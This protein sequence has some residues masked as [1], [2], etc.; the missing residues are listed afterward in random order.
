MLPNGY[1]EG[2]FTPHREWKEPESL[3]LLPKPRILVAGTL[4]ERI[5]WQGIARTS[6]LRPN[7]TWIFVGPGDRESREKLTA[8]VP[9]QGFYHPA[10]PMEE[11]P[12]WIDHSDAAAIPYRL[13]AFT[14][15]SNPVKAIEYLAMGAPV[16]STRV[17]SLM[18]LGP[19]IEWVDE[20]EGESY[21]RAL[22]RIGEKPST[23]LTKARR[24]A[25]MEGES[26][27]ARF[28]QFREAVLSRRE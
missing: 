5:D 24:H 6:K 8:L 19:L 18:S 28:E 3:R 20:G 4:S 16:L 14:A 10:V 11:V 27:Q 25:L 15:A 22:D 9:N 26:R 1:D 21:A 2:V 7:W 23:L 17:P 13:N 12:A